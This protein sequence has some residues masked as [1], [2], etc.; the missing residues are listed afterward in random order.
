MLVCSPLWAWQTNYSGSFT[1][2]NFKSY[3]SDNATGGL[4]QVTYVS[5]ATITAGTHC[6]LG[7]T[8]MP[9]SAN[10][11]NIVS[12]FDGVS[13]DVYRFDE[14]F[15]DESEAPALSVGLNNTRWFP[16]PRTLLSGLTIRQGPKTRV[17]IYY[18]EI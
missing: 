14:S 9:L 13:L 17:I 7:Y 3:V 5:T 10:S 8:I 4:Y 18:T 1:K 15:I 16:Y 2:L 11:E 6:I 12:L